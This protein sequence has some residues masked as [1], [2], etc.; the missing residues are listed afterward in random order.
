MAAPPASSGVLALEAS[1]ATFPPVFAT[2]PF[3]D[4][5]ALD[6]LR[7]CPVVLP[8]ELPEDRLA[9]F[10]RV[11][12]VP[13]RPFAELLRLPEELFRLPEEPLP[14]LD[15]VELERLRVDRLLEDRVVCA[16]VIA[17]LGCWLPCQLRLRTGLC[18]KGYPHPDVFEQ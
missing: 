8:L 10:A 4:A 3:E 16:M 2:A 1:W 12:E 7:D 14:L 17:S 15:L 9:L 18:K 6:R 11:V 13:F 5:V